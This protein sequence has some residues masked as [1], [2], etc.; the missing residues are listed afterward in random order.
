MEIKR[1]G[2]RMK[3]NWTIKK[4]IKGLNVQIREPTFVKKKGLHS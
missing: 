1:K 2:G 3:P 4:K